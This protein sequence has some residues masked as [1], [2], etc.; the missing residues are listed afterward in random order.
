MP[1]QTK[2]L[3]AR[4]ARNDESV[5]KQDLAC[6]PLQLIGLVFGTSG[7]QH[8]LTLAGQLPSSLRDEMHADQRRIVLFRNMATHFHRVNTQFARNGQTNG[9]VILQVIG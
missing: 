1:T 3:I 9:P 7:G 8:T 5:L 2:Y 4:I 6:R